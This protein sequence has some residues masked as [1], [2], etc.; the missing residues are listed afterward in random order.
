MSLPNQINKADP[1]GT[2]AANTADDQLRALKLFLED[3][4]GIP[5]ATN[6]SAAVSA[7][8]TGGVLTISQSGPTMT[9]PKVVT[10]LD[11]TNGNEIFS[12]TAT[13]SAVNNYTVANA[14][15]GN[16]PQLSITGS[17]SNISGELKGAKGT[18]TFTI[19]DS[20]GN[21]VIQAGAAVSSA[22]N[23]LRV[24]ASASGDDVELQAQGSDTNIGLKLTPKG[25]GSID[26]GT[27][28]GSIGVSTAA[29]S[30]PAAKTLYEDTVVKMWVSKTG[31]GT[32]AI[33][34][35]VN[36]SSITDVGTGDFTPVFAT[37]FSSANYGAG[38]IC[39]RTGSAG[40]TGTVT[41][42]TAAAGS[43]RVNCRDSG[44]TIEDS[45]FRL[46]AVGNN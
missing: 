32:P 22:A 46:V 33:G 7:I 23:Y 24:L 15:A 41:E 12:L 14:A 29:G 27:G 40:E 42:H 45:N 20:N 28:F 10:S 19:L 1:A 34:D 43:F 3:L 6:I 2:D 38:A 21:E 18:G 11:D 44:N 13:G 37:N 5:D 35:D 9:R 26:F 8:T 17:D 36:V 31:F 16:A 4:F 30:T 39:R 25:S